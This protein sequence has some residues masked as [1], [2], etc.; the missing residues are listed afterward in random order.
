MRHYSFTI[1]GLMAFVAILAL[2]IFALRTPSRFWANAWFSLALAGVSFAITA[3]VASAGERRAYWSGFAVAGGLY[4]AFALAPWIDERTSHQLLTTTILDLV[5]PYVV[6]NEYML[7]SYKVMAMTPAVPDEPTLWQVWNLPDFRT[8]ANRKWTIGY[9]TLH[10]PFVYLRIG[11]AA[12][13]LVFGFV[14]GEVA[15]FLFLGRS[16]ASSPR[17]VA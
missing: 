6:K 15:R 9:V 13:C 16:P 12:F 11:H 2:A 14:G 10:S 5:S 17:E 3:A 1:R 7:T 8:T 4:F